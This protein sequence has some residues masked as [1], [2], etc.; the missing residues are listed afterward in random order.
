MEA[1]FGDEEDP[2]VESPLDEWS[3]SRFSASHAFIIW[4]PSVFMMVLKK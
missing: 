3:A 1:V 4:P 2:K